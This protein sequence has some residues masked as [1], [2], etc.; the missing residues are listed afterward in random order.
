MLSLSHNTFLTG[1]KVKRLMIFL[2]DS[3]NFYIIFNKGIH[4]GYYVKLEVDTIGKALEVA[5]IK[6]PIDDW[7]YIRREVPENYKYL[8]SAY[9]S[10]SKSITEE[11]N[12]HWKNLKEKG[13]IS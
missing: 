4:E 7:D 9:W 6:Y 1:L 13:I 8:E 11:L 2:M 10:K 5:L 12:E 3:N